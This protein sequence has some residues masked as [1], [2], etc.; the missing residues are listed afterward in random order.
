MRRTLILSAVC[1]GLSWPALSSL[2]LAERDQAVKPL[3]DAYYFHAAKTFGNQAAD[4]V[5]LLRQFAPTS[6]LMPTGWAAQHLGAVRSNAASTG[7]AYSQLSPWVTDHP[8]GAE[9]LSEIQQQYAEVLEIC[10][11]LDSALGESVVDLV[12]V[13][14]T[15][16]K[17][18][19]SLSGARAAQQELALEFGGDR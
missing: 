12:A 14:R 19:S 17:L 1:A 13:S 11:R 5:L 7:W 15:I 16:D 8:D 2:A 4:H 9:Q 6:R 18:Q 10:D 3:G